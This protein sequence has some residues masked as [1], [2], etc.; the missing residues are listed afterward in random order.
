[1]MSTETAKSRQS[2][3]RSAAAAQ[4][5]IR[6]SAAALGACVRIRSA[7]EA[8]ACEA[9]GCPLPKKPSIGRRSGPPDQTHVRTVDSRLLPNCVPQVS[10]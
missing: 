3:C 9:K 2:G 4:A 8:E 10:S 5:Q 6:E 1:M 7:K